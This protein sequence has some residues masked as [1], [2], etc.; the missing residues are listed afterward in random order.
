MGTLLSWAYPSEKGAFRAARDER[1]SRL[2]ALFAELPPQMG[3][4]FDSTRWDNAF[5]QFK[6]SR[7]VRKLTMTTLI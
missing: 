5:N 7:Q 1:M 3:A 6:W 2:K 4:E